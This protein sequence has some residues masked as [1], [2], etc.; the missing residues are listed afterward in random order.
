MIEFKLP[1]L[2]ADMDEGMLVA[3][4]IAPGDTVER[5]Q[6]IAE[7]ETDKGIIEVECWGEGY[8]DEL[9]LEPSSTKL[10]VGTPIAVLRGTDETAPGER[11]DAHG[12]KVIVEPSSAVD[13]VEVDETT[14]TGTVS[15]VSPPVRHLAHELGVDIDH[16]DPTGDGGEVTRDDVR[17]AS[18]TRPVPDSR[19]RA[20]PRARRCAAER[21]IDL[22]SVRPAR[23][24]GL[25]VKGDL[26]AAL[27]RRDDVI[28]EPPADVHDPG[29]AMRRAIGRSMERSKREIP[30]YYLGTQIDIAEMMR[31]LDETNEERSI[32]KRI[33]PAAVLLRAVVL[34]LRETPDLN[35]HWTDGAFVPIRDIHLG[36][37]VSLRKGG[38]VAPAILNA[39]RL[40]LDGIMASLTDLV[41]RARSGRLRSSEM[42]DATITVTSLGDRGV[43]TVFPIIVPPQVAMVGFGKIEQRPVVVDGSV[44]ARTVVNASLT[45][46][47]RVTDGHGG[48]LFLL[49]VDRLLQEPEN[50]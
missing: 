9:L 24:D 32:T 23:L 28:P 49:A 27:P 22:G 31:W 19:P 43:D 21:G 40:D 37:A 2:G 16:L 11:V 34:A 18:V 5:G 38:L 8:V 25:I 26:P 48:G 39:D 29:R 30:H 36:V 20:T 46:D 50:L 33:L 41:A 1:S 15:P 10:A 45:A 47:H 7:V 3:W 44:I 42:S 6:V 12:E 35:G 4:L 17:R 14:E 13:I